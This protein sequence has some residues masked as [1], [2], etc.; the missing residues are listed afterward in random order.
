MKFE[1]PYVPGPG[2]LGPLYWRN[3]QSRVLP[4]AVEAYLAAVLA[5]CEM[6]PGQFDLV[7]AYCIYWIDAPCWVWGD[8]NEFRKYAE[9]LRAATSREAL[10]AALHDLMVFGVDPF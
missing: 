6:A 2:G 7:K 5:D 9:A 3:D 1:A 8:G 4:V 10:T